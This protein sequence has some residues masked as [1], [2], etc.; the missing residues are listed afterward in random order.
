MPARGSPETHSPPPAWRGFSVS[1]MGL[2]FALAP[3]RTLPG[4]TH[5]GPVRPA[6]LA[7]RETDAPAPPTAH[8]QGRSPGGRR[9]RGLE[10]GGRSSRGWGGRC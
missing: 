6:I 8:P 9:A 2:G 1:G 7:G 4:A 10:P 3:G 5:R